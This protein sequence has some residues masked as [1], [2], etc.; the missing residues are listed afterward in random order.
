MAEWD[1]IPYDQLVWGEKLGQGSFGL[2][3][4]GQPPLTTPSTDFLVKGAD[5]RDSL[6]LACDGRDV[7]RHR[8]RHQ[9]GAARRSPLLS[10]PTPQN[11]MG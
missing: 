7:P 4:K 6:L 2:V 3:M 8:H 11:V 5:R 10:D 1:A 9:G